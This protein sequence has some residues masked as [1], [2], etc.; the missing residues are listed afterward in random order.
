LIAVRERVH[1][2]L[3]TCQAGLQADKD[4]IANLLSRIMAVEETPSSL[5]QSGKNLQQSAASIMEDISFDKVQGLPSLMFWEADTDIAAVRNLGTL[6]SYDDPAEVGVIMREGKMQSNS[7]LIPKF[8][9][10][11]C[12]GGISRRA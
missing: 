11:K 3:E 4:E 6:E 9:S 8:R 7:R 1:T 2:S 5:I 10:R 12:P